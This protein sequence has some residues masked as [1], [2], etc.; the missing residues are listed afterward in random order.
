MKHLK[1]FNIPRARLI[2]LGV[3]ALIISSMVSS[4]GTFGN[5][6]TK[7]KRPSFI[8]NAPSDVVI[9]IDG[10][11]VALESELFASTEYFN[12]KGSMNYYT[13]AVNIPYKKP[14][15]LEIS[16]SSMG[17]TAMLSLTPKRQGAIFWGNLIF[18]PIVGHII[19]GVTDNNKILNPRYID[20]TSALNNIPLKDWPSQ[21]KLKRQEKA[22]AKATVAR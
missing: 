18:F 22:K 7:G 13:A 1:L 4:C 9:K 2:L 8:V 11:V 19:D 6:L 20:V 17:K 12:S 21:G 10:K 15:T 16:S 3:F 5:M 14:V